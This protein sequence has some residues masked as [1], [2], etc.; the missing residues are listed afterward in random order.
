MQAMTTTFH[1]VVRGV[2]IDSG[3]LLVAQAKRANNT[4][5]PGGHIDAGEGARTALAREFKEEMDLDV[6]VG[7]FIGAVENQWQTGEVI[8]SEI[9]LLFAVSIKGENTDVV[10]QEPHLDFYWHDIKAIEDI[11]LKPSPLVEIIRGVSHS[12]PS[13]YWA[14]TLD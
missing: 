1:Y 11:N 8:N 9:N 2:L 3:R 7:D 13:A 14:S 10:S 6:V 12:P 4:F 5:L